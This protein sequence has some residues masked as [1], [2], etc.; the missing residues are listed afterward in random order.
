MGKQ[1][2]Q[3]KRPH[4][5]GPSGLMSVK[6]FDKIEDSTSIDR[7]RALQNAYEDVQSH[8]SEIKLLALQI[9]ETMAW[10]VSMAENI[11]KDGI[12]KMVGPLLL[13]HNIMIQAAAIS[14][15]RQIAD[16]GGAKAHA[17]LMN[18]DIMT[19]VIALLK[20]HYS[21]WSFKS[22]YK[23][24]LNEK[25]IYIQ[26]VALLW[27]LC[28]SNDNAIKY[29]NDQNLVPLLTRYL[30]MNIYDIQIIVITMQCLITVVEDNADAVT[31]VR[32]SEDVLYDI[33]I[34]MSTEDAKSNPE[35]WFL[36]TSS[37]TLLSS[38]CSWDDLC[39]PTY[40]NIFIKTLDEV[41]SIDSKQLLSSLVSI[42]PHEKTTSNEKRKK[43]A[44]NKMLVNTQNLA[45]ETLAN[46]C[47]DNDEDNGS[48][49]SDDS[50]IM[51][52]DSE[53]MDIDD[54]HLKSSLP[55]QFVEA[56]NHCNLLDKVWE[57]TVAVEADSKDILNQNEE[58]KDVLK[59]FYI[60]RCRAYMCLNNLLPNFD[61][62]A[63]GGVD[64]FYSKWLEVLKIVVENIN[65]YTGY[66]ELLDAAACALRTITERLNC[67]Q[68]DVFT[69]LNE[70]DFPKIIGDE[71]QLQCINPN[72]RVNM[73]RIFGLLTLNMTRHMN[74]QNYTIAKNCSEVILNTCM[75]EPKAWVM[76]E[77]IDALMDIF[78]EDDT[79]QL[80]VD[81]NLIQKL[82]I[83]FPIF[84]NKVQQQKN[85][86]RDRMAV[87]ST[88]KANIQRFI[89]YKEKQVKN[90]LL[91][92]KRNTIRHT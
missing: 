63:L 51:D 66:T 33:A 87:V 49:N 44:E 26:S 56:V 2:R 3:R 41:L 20:Q 67:V 92:K 28:E 45:L 7:I 24:A 86:L 65:L 15:L 70:T 19:P 48:T 35:V 29:V 39:K 9:L 81:V 32:A 71:I 90:L 60:L 10:D 74:A 18:D 4:K 61:I 16:K 17:S 50:K 89:K 57:K 14:T 55:I 11:A 1:K 8:D 47:S 22:D 88:V 52:M 5:Q 6:D 80:A 73:M 77:S 78:A 69:R 76:A 46:F 37:I 40:F 43:I 25:E 21:N 30:N 85:K 53:A 36:R 68:T 72:T 91:L 42:V 38:I 58:G 12:A 27:T 83:L 62:D 13:D 84:R 31:V 75:T 59:Q 79:D 54:E 82:K 64:K 34:K 23:Y